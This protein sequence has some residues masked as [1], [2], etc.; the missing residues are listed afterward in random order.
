M[1]QLDS[2]QPTAHSSQPTAHPPPTQTPEDL[3]GFASVTAGAR[4][5]AFRGTLIK[6]RA[7]DG[8]TLSCSSGC[9]SV[10]LLIAPAPADTLLGF[11]VTLYLVYITYLR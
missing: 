1:A 3:L 7:A 8:D 11:A 4:S 9:G 2:P 6:F 5:V 10:L